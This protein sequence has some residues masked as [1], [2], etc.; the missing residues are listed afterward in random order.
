M[1]RGCVHCCAR[2]HNI[3]SFFLFCFFFCGIFI[4]ISGDDTSTHCLTHILRPNATGPSYAHCTR[5]A[6]NHR[7]W[8]KGA[9]RIRLRTRARLQAGT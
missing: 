1:T 5:N 7:R 3:V 9:F 8:I 2:Y 6:T 4:A